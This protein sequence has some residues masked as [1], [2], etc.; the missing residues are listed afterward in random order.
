MIKAYELNIPKDIQIDEIL[1]NFNH[2]VIYPTINT[3]KNTDCKENKVFTK[4]IAMGEAKLKILFFKVEIAQEYCDNPQ[5]S[6]RFD[7]YRGYIGES[8]KS[9]IEYAKAKGKKISYLENTK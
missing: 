6:V 4:R 7:G 3:L 2:I 8:T 5:Y 1:N 9:E